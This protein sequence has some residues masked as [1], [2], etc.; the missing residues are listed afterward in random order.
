MKKIFLTALALLAAVFAGTLAG[1]G[2]PASSPATVSGSITISLP[3]DSRTA[4]VGTESVFTPSEAPSAASEISSEASSR[5]ASSRTA[6][7]APASSATSSSAVS[8]EVTS[9]RAVSSGA[10]SSEESE[11]V[12]SEADPSE[13]FVPDPEYDWAAIL[14][15]KNSPLPDGYDP[16]IGKL[17][18]SRKFDVRVLPYMKAMIAAAEKDG[19]HLNVISSYRAPSRQVELFDA[20][21][22]EY[23]KKGLPRKEAELEAGKLVAPPGTSEHC[24]GLAADIVSTDWYDHHSSLTDD[25]DQ[26]EEYRWLAKHAVEYGFVL[27]YPKDKEDITMIDYEPWHYRFVGTHAAEYIKANGLCLEEYVERFFAD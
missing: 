26:T 16:E 1:C 4:S 22:A 25:F 9:S 7:S 18:A 21:V 8:S 5:A 19:I 24:T 6:S 10:V 12:S 14:V 23:R 15:N 2:D 13:E 20:K 17:N 11:P 27:R 3:A